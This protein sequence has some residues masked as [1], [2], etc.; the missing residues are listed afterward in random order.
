V[1]TT[2][3]G[4]PPIPIVGV[5]SGGLGVDDVDR[6]E[7]DSPLAAR[8]KL[9]SPPSRCLRAGPPPVLIRERLAGLGP[10]RPDEVVDWFAWREPDRDAWAATGSHGDPPRRG[11]VPPKIEAY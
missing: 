2:P 6:R 3:L 9:G 1:R 11:H 10:R 4:V 5:P 7:A 8:D